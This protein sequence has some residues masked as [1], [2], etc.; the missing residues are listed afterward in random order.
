[1]TKQTVANGLQVAGGVAVIVAAFLVS[2]TLGAFVAGLLAV[3]AGVIV[4]RD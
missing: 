4:E 3:V 2:V 1:M